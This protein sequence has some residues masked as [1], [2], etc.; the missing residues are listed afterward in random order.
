MILSAS[1]N[2][3]AHD[4][5]AWR[6]E[7]LRRDWRM[8]AAA[9]ERLLADRLEK[10]PASVAANRMTALDATNREL[11]MRDL[12]AIWRA[13]VRKEPIPELQ[14]SH[15]ATRADLEAAATAWARIAKSRPGDQGCSNHAARVA[16]LAR[17]HQSPAPSGTPEIVH[18]HEMNQHNRALA[19]SRPA[20]PAPKPAPAAAP[21]PTRAKA[22]PPQQA[23]LF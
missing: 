19:A 12:V 9:A 8:L 20:K 1:P 10:D 23:G 5:D 2:A 3:P 22:P 17:Y 6:L 4:A 21:S 16:A 11:T 13:V 7:G 15:A 14:V 18:L